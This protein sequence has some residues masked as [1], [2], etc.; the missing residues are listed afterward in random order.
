MPAQQQVSYAD[1]LAWRGR[2]P[3]WWGIRLR[4]AG[5]DGPEAAAMMSAAGSK[6]L[7][8]ERVTLWSGADQASEGRP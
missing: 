7:D 5:R 8:L 6:L 3:R 1:W 2:N 4:H